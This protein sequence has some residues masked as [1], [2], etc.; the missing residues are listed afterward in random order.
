MDWIDY[1]KEEELQKDLSLLTELEETL[2]CENNPRLK[3]KWLNEI[4]TA[5]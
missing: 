5:E 2:R 3:I 4:A 1:I